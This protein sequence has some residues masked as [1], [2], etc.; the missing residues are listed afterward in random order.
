MWYHLQRDIVSV[1]IEEARERASLGSVKE[2][3]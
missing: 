1:E 2:I 3:L